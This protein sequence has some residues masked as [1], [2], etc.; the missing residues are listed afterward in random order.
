[1]REAN[2][3]NSDKYFHSKAN[4]QA[5]LRGIGGWKAA[6]DIS[7]FREWYDQNVKGDSESDSRADQIANAYGRIR[8]MHYKTWQ[9]PY[10]N[11]KEA[12]PFYRPINLPDKY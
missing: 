2:W 4:F 12:I 1:M 6:V 10:I 11:Y 9:R 3:K 5:S 7:N 8:S